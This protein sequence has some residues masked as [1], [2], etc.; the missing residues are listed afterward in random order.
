MYSI[1]V[2]ETCNQPPDLNTFLF[3]ISPGLLLAADTD[4]SDERNEAVERARLAEQAER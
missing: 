3:R 2:G 1:P 4:M